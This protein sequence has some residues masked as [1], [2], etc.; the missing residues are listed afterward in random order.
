MVHSL[1]QKI[2]W[3]EDEVNVKEIISDSEGFTVNKDEWNFD[4]NR[5]DAAK[6]TKPVRNLHL[7]SCSGPAEQ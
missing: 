7:A 4:G 5:K 1:C 3:V 6:I 2:P